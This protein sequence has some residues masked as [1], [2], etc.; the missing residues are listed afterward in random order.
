MPAEIT[1]EDVKR[2]AK[3][4]NLSLTEDEVTTFSK[5]FTETLKYMDML[6]ELDTSGVDETYQ[7]TGLKNVF[8]GENPGITLSKEQALANASE[9]VDGYFGT[10]AVFD[11]E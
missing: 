7:V 9:V 11:R 5:L 3:I 10:K 4:S 2:I 8:Q 6:N 1:K